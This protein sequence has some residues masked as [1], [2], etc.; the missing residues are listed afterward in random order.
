MKGT[1]RK[2]TISMITLPIIYVYMT[3]CIYY[4]GICMYVCMILCIIKKLCMQVYMRM[5]VWM[6]GCIRSD[7][8]KYQYIYTQSYYIRT[9][10]FIYYVRVYTY[11]HVHIYKMY[12][13][14]RTGKQYIQ[15]TIVYMTNVYTYIH[16]LY[17]TNMY[18]IM[19]T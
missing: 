17:M 19:H 13:Y 4:I 10:S 2:Y 18:T 14:V 5:Y 6:Y 16:K 12:N 8:C 9:C 1:I 3:F 7:V 11:I 15:Y